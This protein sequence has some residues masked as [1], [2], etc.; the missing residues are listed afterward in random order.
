[1]S[2]L[3]RARS[4]INR[5]RKIIKIMQE[6]YQP[7]LIEQQAQAFWAE[8]NSFVV[9]EDPD[10]EKYYCLA[11]FPYPS[12]RL[13]M[14]HV[15]NYSIADVIARYQRMQGKNVL[16]P[17]GW[18]AFGLPAENAA[19][20]NQ[21]PP[22]Q[23]TAANIEVMRKQF[24]R[25]GFAYDWS[26]ELTTCEPDYY[27]WEQWFFTR[28]YEQGLVY[29]K[30]TAV[31]WCPQDQTVLANE[32]VIDGRCWRCETAVEQRSIPQWFIKITAYAEQLLQGL[33][34]LDGWPER[35][36]TMQRHWIGRSEGVALQF[37]LVEPVVDI[38]QIS[39]Y[40]TRPDTL[41]GVT[42]LSI[43]AEH[44]ISQYLADHNPAIAAFIQACQQ[45]SN[46]EADIATLEK[47][48]IATAIEAIHPLSGERLP[49]WIANYVLAGYG[50]GAVMAVPAH[51]ERDFIFANQYQLPI[52]QVVASNDEQDAP[53]DSQVWQ[54]WYVRKSHSITINS[55]EFDGLNFNDAYSAIADKLEALGKGSRQV[56]YRL[57]DWG[58][59]RQRY[60]GTP[61]PIEYLASGEDIAVPLE[62]LPVL[63]PT[64]V[65]M[66]GVNSP[67][68]Q[69]SQWRYRQFNGQTIAR[70]TDTF[71]TFMESSWYYARFTCPHYQQ[72]MLDPAAANYWLPVDR[73]VGGIEHAIL[74]LLYARFFHKL[75]RDQGLVDCDEP[76]TH[77][78][79]QGMVLKDGA[80]MSKSK[81]N[82]VDPEAMIAKYGADTVRLFIMF[83]APPE[84]S[85]EWSDSAVGGAHK[86]LQ[87]LWRLVYQ[88]IASP[89]VTIDTPLDV[90]NLTDQQQALRRQL[91]MTIDKVS[92]DYQRRLSFNTAIAAVMEL[93]N[94]L[95]KVQDHS[96]QD[97][98]LQREALEA[99]ILMLAPI[100]PHVTHSLWHA[101]GHTIAVIDA[102]WPRVD[103]NA[104]Q[105]AQLTLVVQVNG[106]V[107][108]KITVAADLDD[109]AII[110]LAL[111][112][113]NVQKFVSGKA[114]VMRKVI[115]GKLVAIAVR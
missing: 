74:H 76:F 69:D 96:V 106:K 52:V 98:I 14:G 35:V 20:A 31:N 6:Q 60:W 108:G 40:T 89:F 93:V 109:Q 15:R 1:M 110:A 38:S 25:L 95:T 114:I 57:H 48:G 77:L 103:A 84:Q 24:K 100:V 99:V 73:Y 29:K 7:E 23:W 66:D 87:R 13:H 102:P 9:H 30:T 70:E 91:H 50:S 82:I 2:N 47:K 19:I 22:A 4:Y 97:W 54:P 16:Q 21:V 111:Q 68:K 72:G 86:F 43:A 112:H 85:L 63:L 11:M 104:L 55:G 49:V 75:M 51:D 113:D 92:D 8:H 62:R 41:M 105:C 53:F 5:H 59:S 45:H 27:R 101:L 81:G 34:Q 17:I 46:A 33:D 39:V 32:Q 67:L 28:L 107:R 65:T 64:E 56:Q 90:D 83:A 61:I 115:P 12:G 3:F 42:Y 88:H 26:R 94:A 37:D 78:L 58:V 71:D 10:K 36:K 18:D 44:P 79:T 80:K